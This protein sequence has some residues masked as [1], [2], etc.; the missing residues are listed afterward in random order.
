MWF[1]VYGLGFI[2]GF[3]EGKEDEEGMKTNIV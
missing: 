1:R 2:V 3:Y